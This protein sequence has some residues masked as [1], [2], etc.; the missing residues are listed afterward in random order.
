MHRARLVRLGGLSLSL[1]A[2]A[3]AVLLTGC[4]RPIVFEGQSALSVVGTPPP[5][6]PAPP[7]PPPEPPPPPPAPPPRVEVRDNKIQINEKIQF[8]YNSAKIKT[9]S[10]S[11]MNEIADVIKKNPHIKKI[12][13][14]G[15]ASAEGNAAY[16]LRL[17]DQ[18][19]KS[20]MKYLVDETQLP[21]EMLTAKGFGVTKP[22]ADNE[23]EE[24]REKNRRVEFNIV[25]QDITQRKIEIDPATGKEK[26]ISEE[27]APTTAPE[28][29]TP[30]PTG[31]E[32]PALKKPPAPQP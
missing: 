11:L 6:P 2:L 16:N 30:A 9:E 15:H 20:V 25:E 22:I 17:S 13:I 23:T 26:V 24:G 4:G 1:G 12:A 7:P 29:T 10:H 19:A 3:A 5:P 18:R 32:K 14:E 27:K 21:A 28:Q 8:E 31:T